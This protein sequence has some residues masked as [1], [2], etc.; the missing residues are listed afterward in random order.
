[1]RRH[2]LALMMIAVLF[3]LGAPA[4]GVQDRTVGTIASEPTADQVTEVPREEPTP[5]PSS[6]TAQ[7]PATATPIPPTTTEALPT[8]TLMP[9]AAL[10]ATE[11]GF[12]LPTSIS[13]V[14]RINP[15]ELKERLDVGEDVTVVD[16]R[17]PEFYERNHIA[18]ALSIPLPETEDRQGELSKEKKIVFY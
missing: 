11:E 7:P 6:P 12:I 9:T 15:Q 10:P 1:M 4:C 2:H 3:A 8:A 17:K 16:S 5:V 18:G 13:Q 14:P